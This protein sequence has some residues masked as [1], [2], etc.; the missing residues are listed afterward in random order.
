MVPGEVANVGHMFQLPVHAIVRQRGAHG[1][2]IEHGN[3]KLRGLRAYLSDADGQAT[4]TFPKGRY[5]VLD[6]WLHFEGVVYEV[7][8]PVH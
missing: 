1:E 2:E 7:H 6:A 5:I 8:S 3:G 4:R